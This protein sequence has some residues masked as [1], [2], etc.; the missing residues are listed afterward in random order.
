MKTLPKLCAT[1]M[2]LLSSAFADKLPYKIS[3]ESVLAENDFSMNNLDTKPWNIR[4]GSW[5]VENGKLSAEAIKSQDHSP[6]MSLFYD[7]P[8]ESLF[9]Y[10]FT[11]N[12][13][14]QGVRVAFF[15][16]GGCKLMIHQHEMYFIVND[17][18]DDKEAVIVDWRKLNLEVGQQYHIDFILKDD[19]VIAFLDGKKALAGKDP[20]LKNKKKR[21]QFSSANQVHT[22]D[23]FKLSKVT[24][25][26]SS[27]PEG[28]F[29]DKAI[30]I[31]EFPNLPG[32]KKAQS[33][34]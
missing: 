30:K 10:D 15:G 2:L 21:F 11:L 25:D 17:K 6:S 3:T 16:K 4:F 13:K 34:K 20:M 27:L 12:A 18:Q 19:K 22:F 1:G 14:G 29:R 33:T 31:S 32:R 7:I 28:F 9:S 8:N 24:F 23:N 26:D 5:T